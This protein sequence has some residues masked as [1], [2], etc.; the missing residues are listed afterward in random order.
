M[1]NLLMM[2]NLPIAAQVIDLQLFADA[3]TAVNATTTITNAY[4]GD[5]EA[6]SKENGTDMSPEMKTY[7]NT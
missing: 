4:T 3:G 2:M 7:Y 1:F 5:T 6:R